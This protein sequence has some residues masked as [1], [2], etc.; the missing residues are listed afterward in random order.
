[1]I[2]EQ[3]QRVIVNVKIE[4]ERCIPLSL[5]VLK[6]QLLKLQKLKVQKGIVTDAHYKHKCK[7][8]ILKIDIGN[9]KK[10]N[11]INVPSYYV[12][13]ESK[14]KYSGDTR[15]NW[16]CKLDVIAPFNGNKNVIPQLE[17]ADGESDE[18]DGM[19]ADEFDQ[20]NNINYTSMFDDF[21]DSD[22]NLPSDNDNLSNENKELNLKCGINGEEE[23]KHKVYKV[24]KL[25]LPEELIQHVKHLKLLMDN[26]LIKNQNEILATCDKIVELIDDGNE[27][28][29]MDAN[30]KARIDQ[31]STKQ[32]H[33]NQQ[34]VSLQVKKI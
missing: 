21:S 20:L 17:G 33:F 18:Y 11:I 34:G 29:V 23:C 30:L 15:L 12:S 3:N 13:A 1:M 16:S 9:N 5:H 6:P 14:Y 2:A 22:D 27:L 28:P 4:N 26:S 7:C 31:A 32:V 10:P 8:W 25:L 24:D 19:S